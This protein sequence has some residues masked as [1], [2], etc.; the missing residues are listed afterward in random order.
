MSV[1]D[2]AKEAGYS[3]KC[4]AQLG[5][6]AL[7]AI[8]EKMPSVLDKAGLTDYALIEK[9]LKPLLEAE[10]TEFAKFQGQ[11]TDSRNVI[12]WG[13]RAQALD[14]AFNLKGSYA[15]KETHALVAAQITFMSLMPEPGWEQDIADP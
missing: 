7:E 9:Y 13:P 2:A 12:A 14:M 5:Y 15:P 11:I 6:Q 1:T 10:E 8:R 4:A 3:E